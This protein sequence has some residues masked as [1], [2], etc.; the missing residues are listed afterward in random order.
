MLS[1]STITQCAA[2]WRATDTHPPARPSHTTDA[3]Q[4]A[5]RVLDALQEVPTARCY[6]MPAIDA[7]RVADETGGSQAGRARSHPSLEGRDGERLEV[8]LGAGAAIDLAA[9]AEAFW[10]RGR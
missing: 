5:A 8:E 7:P 6:E 1:V 2:R 4:S 3:A 9:L 10:R